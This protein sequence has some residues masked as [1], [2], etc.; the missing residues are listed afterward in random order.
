KGIGETGKEE[1]TGVYEKQA[2]EVP[3]YF[4]NG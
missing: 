1:S 4:C 3:G 2:E